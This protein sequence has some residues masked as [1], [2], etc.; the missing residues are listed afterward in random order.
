MSRAAP[1]AANR[2]Q[3]R[4]T[5]HLYR[6]G[7]SKGEAMNAKAWARIAGVLWLATIGLGLFGE[8]VV[9]SRLITSDADTTLSNVLTHEGAYRLGEA[10]LL[11]GTATYLALTAIMYRLLAPVSRN[12][13]L[14]AAFFSVVGCVFWMFSLVGDAAPLVFLADGRSVLG[15]SPETTRALTFAFMKLHSETLLLGML[16]FGVHCLLMGILIV[17]ASFLPALIGIVLGLGGVCYMAAGYFHTLSPDLYAQF[18]RFLFLPGEA[19]E[20]A[21][22]LWLAIVGLNAAKWTDAQT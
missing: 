12:L 18:G 22:A 21:I 16:C 8:A 13:S 2:I 1:D 10:A 14:I 6:I 7:S 17:R 15:A 9:R 19:G 5:P 11:T 4:F 20:I 3:T